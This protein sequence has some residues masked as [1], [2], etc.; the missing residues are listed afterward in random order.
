LAVAETGSKYEGFKNTQGKIHIWDTTTWVEKAVL[1]SDELSA[2]SLA[3]NSDGSYLAVGNTTGE[4]QL[5]Y[6]D[7]ERVDKTL[8]GHDTWVN[9]LAF[10]PGDGLLISGSGAVYATNSSGDSTVRLWSVSPVSESKEDLILTE[11][12]QNLGA[13][14]SVGFSPDGGVIAAGLSNKTVHLWGVESS[15]ELAILDGLVWSDDLL[16]T[17]DSKQIL[18]I[19]GDGVRVWNLADAV[20]TSGNVPE[21]KLIAPLQEK[22][23]IFSIALTPD[24]T[25]LAAGY[26]DG[27]VRLWDMDTGE[28]LTVLEG[29]TDRVVSL[30]FSPDGTLLAS[31]G[32]DGTVR[33]WGVPGAV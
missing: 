22:E 18:F 2:M 13:G 30:A 26:Q 15:R 11:K 23:S 10:A 9:S 7:L 20:E 29:H 12:D 28:Q 32:A 27:T 19:S 6:L 8:S 3:F 5:W 21:Y 16:F 1:T 31:G 17:P 4:I 24:G 14:L 33:L 25:V